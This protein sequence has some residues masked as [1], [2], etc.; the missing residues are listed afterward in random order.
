MS[1]VDQSELKSPRTNRLIMK[2]TMITKRRVKLMLRKDNKGKTRFNWRRMGV[3][4]ILL[5]LIM[6]QGN[7]PIVGVDD[8]WTPGI[9]APVPFEDH[10]Q[11][12]HDGVTLPVTFEDHNYTLHT[13]DGQGKYYYV[14]KNRKLH[15]YCPETD[16]WEMDLFKHPSAITT[17]HATVNNKIFV[18]LEDGTIYRS[19]DGG[20]SFTI[21]YEWQAGGFC[22]PTW[23]IASSEKWVLIGEYGTKD[24]NRQVCASNNWGDTWIVVYE[25]PESEGVHIHRVAID[26]YTN[27]WWVTVGDIPVGRRVLYSSDH[28]TY[29]NKVECPE[30]GRPWQ[31][32]Q[33]CNILFFEHDILL[34]NEPLPQVFEVDRKTMTAVYIGEIGNF[35]YPDLAPPYSL[36]VG[37]HGIYA[38]IVR[39]PDPKY[40][41]DA[42]IFVSYDDGYT[43]QRLMNFT[44]WAEKTYQSIMPLNVYGS[45]PIIYADG[46]VHARWVFG[47]MK[48]SGRSG[49]VDGGRAFKFKDAYYIPKIQKFDVIWHN[50]TY[51]VSI[52]SNSIATHFN[53]NQTLNQISFNVSGDSS[54]LGYCNITIPKTL[55]KDSPERI[56]IDDM[57]TFNFILTENI[58]HFFLYF[59][60]THPNIQHI[61]IQGTRGAPVVTLTSVVT[62]ISEFQLA[63]ILPIF[64]VV[65]MIKII[66]VKRRLSKKPKT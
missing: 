39:Y 5:L 37:N 8:T 62:L 60:Y 29:W 40:T 31:P 14:E 23:S 12:L 15:R 27:N 22:H 38:S 55:L 26:P 53:Y 32:W 16:S 34:I 20:N 59:I 28:G 54:T 24:K 44:A 58:T 9:T 18:G 1:L 52:H 3:L 21:T 2:S 10:R 56:T 19:I 50:I 45:N 49:L 51:P 64:I 4:G 43:W 36:V 35:P 6:I 7:T 57:P 66:L 42:G 30:T 13:V 48:S 46:Y 61:V 63:L 17:V 47:W 33:P 11:I 41:H 65:S 25:T